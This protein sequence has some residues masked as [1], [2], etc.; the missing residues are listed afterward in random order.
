MPNGV[1]APFGATSVMLVVRPQ[2]KLVGKAASDRDALPFVEALERALLDLVGDR[3]QRG[4][5]GGA[6][7]AHQHPGGIERRGGKRLAF[8]DRGG[9]LQAFDLGD[10]GGDRL[11][12]GQ[13]RVQRLDQQMAVEAQNLVEQFL[14]ESIHHRHDDDQ[15]RNAEHDAEERKAGDDRDKSLLPPRPQI[16]QRQHPFEGAK[17]VGSGRIGHDYVPALDFHIDSGRF[18][19]WTGVRSGQCAQIIAT[20]ARSRRPG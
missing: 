4:E 2:R 17:G 11:P 6:H 12:V 3:G 15:G 10:A 14:A 18:T 8:H 5:I 9:Q 1:I 19:P 7:A 20:A 13:R 16:A